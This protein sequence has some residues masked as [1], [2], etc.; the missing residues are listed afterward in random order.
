MFKF[1]I[2]CTIFLT[3]FQAQTIHANDEVNKIVT[4]FS[5]EYGLHYVHALNPKETIYSLS[6]FSGASVQEIYTINRLSSTSILSI[7][8]ELIIPVHPEAV[9]T[10]AQIANAHKQSLVKVMYQVKKKDN[11]FQIAKRHFT[12]D[13]NTIVERNGLS[14]LTISPDQLLHIGWISLDK[15]FPI[16]FKQVNTAPQQIVTDAPD[17]TS[18][19]GNTTVASTTTTSPG[20]TRSETYQK[21]DDVIKTRTYQTA[22]EVVSQAVETVSVESDG[23]LGITTA[24][25]PKYRVV[26]HTPLHK[27]EKTVTTPAVVDTEVSGSVKQSSSQTTITEMPTS[28]ESSIPVMEETEMAETEIHTTTSTSTTTSI[29]SNEAAKKPAS[30]TTN[31]TNNETIKSRDYPDLSFLSSPNLLTIKGIA[32]WD[33]NDNEPLNMFILHQDAKIGSYIRIENPMLGRIVLAK[34]VARLPTNVYDQD[35]KMVVSSAVASSLGVKD[36][37]FL[38][39]MKYIR[40]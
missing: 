8:Q 32:V 16:A 9:I 38:A 25:K 40:L 18:A 39:E 15:N 1:P 24:E 34:V 10:D 12:T 35:V 31:S 14:G 20:V 19:Y 21:E 11:L 33:K 4:S 28:S 22:S 37:R 2:V 17:V 27:K 30:T 26:Q 23:Q 3:L 29:P 6:K 7:S 5:T 36:S 13:I